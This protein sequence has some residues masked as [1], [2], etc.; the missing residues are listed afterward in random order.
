VAWYGLEA[1]ARRG[2]AWS[3]GRGWLGG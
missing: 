1:Y 3:A 2:V